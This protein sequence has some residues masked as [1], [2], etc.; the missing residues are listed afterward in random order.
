[1]AQFIKAEDTLINKDRLVAVQ[2]K[3]AENGGAFV[4]QEHYLAV[5]DTGEKVWLSPTEG[6]ALIEQCQGRPGTTATT[7][8]RAT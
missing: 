5:F 2:Y 6:L 8:A 7:S 3:P 1:M 4:S